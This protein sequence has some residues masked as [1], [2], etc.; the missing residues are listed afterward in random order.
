M[1][2]IVRKAEPFSRSEMKSDEAIKRFEG[3]GEKY[4]VELIEDLGVDSVSL[5]QQGGFTDLCRGPHRAVPQRAMGGVPG[6][7][8]P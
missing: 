3:E 5:Y 6:G 7:A 4:K 1:T 8:P 2:E